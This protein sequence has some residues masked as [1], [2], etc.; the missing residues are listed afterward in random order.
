ML[1]RTNL[2]M[3]A[4][5]FS[6]KSHC[7]TAMLEMIDCSTAYYWVTLYQT[8]LAMLALLP[9]ENIRSSHQ[10]CRLLVAFLVVAGCC[11]PVL[12]AERG[13]PRGHDFSNWHPTLRLI[14]PHPSIST[15]TSS[16][17]EMRQQ[18]LQVGYSIIWKIVSKSSYHTIFRD[19]YDLKI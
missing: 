3:A 16:Y 15:I 9:H 18:P 11:V 2:Q 8:W 19:N 17:V 12:G 4:T 13:S 14:R 1:E 6:C 7:A 10:F 5:V